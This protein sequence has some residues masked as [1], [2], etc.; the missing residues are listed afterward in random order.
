MHAN[1]SPGVGTG[2]R[3]TRA[4]AT[5]KRTRTAPQAS[6]DPAPAIFVLRLQGR[7]DHDIR[8]LRLLL[9]QFLRRHGFH[10]LSIEEERGQT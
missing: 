1:K 10:T 9:K 4:A 8:F 3:K 6:C 7:G 5:N 2:A